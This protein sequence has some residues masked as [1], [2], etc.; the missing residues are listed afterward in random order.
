MGA[1]DDTHRRAFRPVVLTGVLAVFASVTGSGEATA[2]AATA[3]AATGG[4]VIPPAPT[5]PL[6]IAAADTP[7]RFSAEGAD[8]CLDCHNS[9]R[10]LWLFRTPH[11]QRGDAAS[12]MAHQQCETCHGPG[13]EHAGRRSPQRGHA[14]VVNFGRDKA[15]PLQD[16]NAVC[17]GCHRN[18]VTPAWENSAHERHDTGCVGCHS[19]HAQVDPVRLRSQQNDVCF[20]C[21]RRQQADARKPHAHPLQT[22]LTAGVGSALVCA[23]CHAPHVSVGDDLL[24]RTTVNNLCF[25]CHAEYRG[26]V[27]FDHAPVSE[28]CS[29]CHRSHGSIHTAMLNRPT[30]LLCQSC[31]SQRGHPSVSF[32]PVGL[33]DGG[34]PSAFLLGRN[35]ANC[36]TQVHGSNHPS[37]A[38]L[39]R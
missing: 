34:R 33:P 14:L 20:D 27:I 29:L 35:C 10:M 23:D 9:E 12:P 16:Q 21:H 24:R 1:R 6:R 39:M 31:H 5:Q 3:S 7:P 2:P 4:T 32:T 25:D 18:A 36:H 30:P 8:T 19:V 15:T 38:G 13:G 26:P 28:D 17:L 37:G 11:G 22:G